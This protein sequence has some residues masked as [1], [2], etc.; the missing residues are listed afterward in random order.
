MDSEYNHNDSSIDPIWER[1]EIMA[2]LRELDAPPDILKRIVTAL[3]SLCS[4]L[5][6][7]EE[8]NGSNFDY[9]N[10]RN[11]YSQKTS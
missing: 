5:E 1:A 2:A 6:P 11:V 10:M 7:F 8:R 3:Q 9:K 4:D